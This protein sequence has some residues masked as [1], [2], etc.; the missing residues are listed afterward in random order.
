MRTII[1]NFAPD[2]DSASKYS[3]L[4]VP[5]LRTEHLFACKTVVT[6]YMMEVEMDEFINEIGIMRDF[7]NIVQLFK[8]YRV[9]RKIWT[10]MELCTGGDM[11]SRIVT[12]TEERLD[13]AM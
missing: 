10:I 8:M 5:S 4:S 2:L 11:E 3:V 9:R 13:I 7:E 1:K 12:M 6:S